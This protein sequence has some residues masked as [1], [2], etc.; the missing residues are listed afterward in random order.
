M[1]L[2][3]VITG[4]L[5][6]NCKYNFQEEHD[7]KCRSKTCMLNVD[8]SIAEE[9]QNK[10]CTIFKRLKLVDANWILERRDEMER[11]Q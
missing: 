7:G 6:I 10:G 11:G 3:R 2:Q 5:P 4:L 8:K 1:S 9:I